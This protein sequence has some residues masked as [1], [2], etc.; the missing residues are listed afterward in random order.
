MVDLHLSLNQ[1]ISQSLW[2]V[3]PR[4][5]YI[6]PS[7]EVGMPRTRQQRPLPEIIASHLQFAIDILKDTPRMMV[8]ENQTP[9]CHSQL[10]KKYMPRAMQGK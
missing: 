10:Y 4:V 9:W 5:V 2:W 1:E 8:Y 3:P 6:P 7:Y